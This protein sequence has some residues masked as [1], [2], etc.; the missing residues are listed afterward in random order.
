MAT[1]EQLMETAFGP[2]DDE[3]IIEFIQNS[4]IIMDYFKKVL[5]YIGKGEVELNT[6]EPF[7]NFQLF[8]TNIQSELKKKKIL[9]ILILSLINDTIYIICIFV[10][11]NC[12]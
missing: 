5:K 4:D 11:N 10:I 7:N 1:S 2:D 3:E 9:I 8:I 6:I 12:A